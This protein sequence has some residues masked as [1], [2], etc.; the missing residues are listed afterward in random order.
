MT[1]AVLTSESEPRHGASLQTQRR[2]QE[3][4]LDPE[5][6]CELERILESPA[7][8]TSSRCRAFLQHVVTYA[9]SPEV[10]KERTLGVTLFGRMPD[11][12]TGADA[13]V[14][15]KASEV[16]RKLAEYSVH[17]NPE[18]DV[19]IELQPGSYAPRISV[20]ML[21]EPSAS[22]KETSQAASATQNN[23]EVPRWRIYLV[24]TALIM[25]S[26]VCWLGL[27]VTTSHSA[28]HR[29][30]GPF[31]DSQKPIICISHP[32][33]YNLSLNEVIGKGD[34]PE[35][36][37]LRDVLLSLGRSSRIGLAQD[38][39]AEDLSSSP[40]IIV[41]G[42][43]F[44]RWTMNLT[45]NLRFAFDVVDDKPRI[46]DRLIPSRYWTD[47]EDS[48]DQ[49]EHGYVIITRLLDTPHQK[50]VLCIAGLRAIDTRVGTEV[51][52][53]GKILNDLFKNAPDDWAKK[54]L[55]WVLL[56]KARG[57]DRPLVEL[58]AATYW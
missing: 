56:V 40:M 45:Q 55:Q 43:R 36:L 3:P 42:P 26:L 39:T 4:T 30:L 47:P 48:A 19:K 13:I 25:L 5:V 32:N 41:G 50:A 53:D 20:R 46:Y 11:Y 17:A 23:D 8:R 44:N 51:I 35:A 1:N 52:S 57:S 33:A 15:V 34:A 12:D 31:L 10:L 27:S 6:L 29:F 54:N 7:F 58:R 18:R 2:S 24:A 21:K 28:D 38:L 16:R 22:E 37:R 49:R 9:H 14:R